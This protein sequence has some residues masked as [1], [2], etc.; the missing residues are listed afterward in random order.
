[1]DLATSPQGG[2]TQKP[3]SRALHHVG[4]SYVAYV[5]GA[6]DVAVVAIPDS[7]QVP[8]SPVVLHAAFQVDTHAAPAMYLRSDNKLLVVY[9]GHNGG[10][11]YQRISVNTLDSDPTL[12]G[13]FTVEATAFSG[14]LHTYPMLV[15]RSSESTATV[16]CFYRDD[17]SGTAVLAYRKSTD[18]GATWGS[19]HEVYK[20]AGNRTYWDIFGNGTDRIDFV[21]TDCAT[22]DQLGDIYHFYADLTDYHKSDGTVISGSQPWAPS[23]L[24]LVY[25][26]ATAGRAWS[27][28]G[29]LDSGGK[30]RFIFGIATNWSPPGGTD[31]EYAYAR[32]SG[33]AWVVSTILA[34][35]GAGQ[36]DPMYGCLDPVEET[37]AYLIRYIS[38]KFELWRYITADNGATWAGVAVTS[39]SS[40]AN[41][42]PVA[43]KDHPS[44][45][46]AVAWIAGTY[47]SATDYTMGIKGLIV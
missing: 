11:M 4:Y 42:Y 29:F 32:W 28:D 16:Y 40:G 26:D 31:T 14:E 37:R 18:D 12:S 30:P 35:G 33:S 1:L 9:C 45:G 3:R 6:G 36:F 27:H 17:Q 47:V 43:V 8:G 7:T 44:P 38:S 22:T 10:L 13:G 5:S 21:V 34:S 41:L 39:A 23:D 19:Q 46:L 25:N 2:W 24:T 15:G 20:S